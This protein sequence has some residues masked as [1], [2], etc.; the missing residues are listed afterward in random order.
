[1]AAGECAADALAFSEPLIVPALLGAPVR[2]A[3][4][5]PVLVS[6]V[7]LLVGLTLTMLGMYALVYTWTRDEFAA[8][9]AGAAFA[10]NTHTLMRLAHLQAMHAY[11]LPLSL[12]ATDRLLTKGRMH[13]A[14]WLALWMTLMAYTSGYFVVFAFFP[15][16]VA[17]AVRA[18]I[19][20]PKAR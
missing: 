17:V 5:S 18:P 7:L 11:G 6:N 19:W 9:V 20:I 14:L 1:M 15:I 16:G 12:L 2:L 13:D 10:F 8:L 4:G 3:G